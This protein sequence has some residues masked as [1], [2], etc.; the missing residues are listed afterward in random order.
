MEPEFAS[1]FSTFVSPLFSSLFLSFTP[2]FSLSSFLFF[3]LF[4]FS[5]FPPSSF[6]HDPSLLLT[7]SLSLSLIPQTFHLSFLTSL[8]F[9][10]LKRHRLFQPLFL[11]ESLARLVRL[12]IFRLRPARRSLFWLC[13]YSVYYMYYMYKYFL[14]CLELCSPSLGNERR[15]TL[16]TFNRPAL[17][18]AYTYLA[19][20]IPSLVPSSSSSSSSPSP[21]TTFEPPFFLSLFLTSHLY[22]RRK[23]VVFSSVLLDPL[24]ELPTV[25]TH[26]FLAAFHSR[27]SCERFYKLRRYSKLSRLL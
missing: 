15:N 2:I 23:G 27:N 6:P 21:W 19:N 8:L 13:V 10:S 14:P 26:E 20:A 7:P 18:S 22:H 17:S 4:L 25:T 24:D 3:P 12:Y 1:R 16:A 9:L 11:S 5:L